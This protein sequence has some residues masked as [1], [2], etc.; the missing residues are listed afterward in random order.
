[1]QLNYVDWLVIALY[2]LFNLAVALYLRKRAT[3][4]VSDFFVSGRNVSWWLAGTSMVA[5]TFAADTPLVVTG[6]VARNGIA[7]NWIWWSMVFSGMLT[8]F[9]YAKLWRRAGVL[10]D[11]EFAEIRYHGKPAAFL[12][13]FRAIY[14]GLP[15]NLI[16]M[17]WVN[18]AIVKIMMSVLGISKIEALFFAILIMFITASISSLSGLWGVLWTDM[19]QFFLKMSMVILLAVYAVSATGGMG[20]LV[21]K[22]HEIDQSRDPSSS[23]LSFVP[24]LNSTWMPMITFFVFIA[25]NWWASWYPGAEPGGGGYVAQRIFCAKNEKHSL[26]ATLWFNI[27]HY[28]LRPW[29]WVIVALVAV[30]RYNNDPAFHADPE[31]GYIRILISDLPSY[32]RGLMLAAFA[33]A[34]MSTIGTQLNWGASY[35]VNDVYRRFIPEKSEKHYVKFSQVVTMVLMILSAIV[36]FY[37]DSIASAWQFLMA[38]G[39][40]TG[41]VYILRWFWWRINAWSEISAMASAFVVSLVLQFGFGLTESNPKDFAYLLLITTGITTAVWLTVTFLTKPEPNEVLLSFYRR[42]RPNATM[43]A[44]IAK[45]ATDIVPQKDGLFNLMNWVSGVIMIYCTLFGVGR[46]VLGDT[47]LGIVLLAIGIFFGG[48]IYYNMNR[49]GWETL[50]A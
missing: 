19:F 50:S 25:V 1:M 21:T 46:I 3:Q 42:V 40:G 15:I 26:L 44:P 13:I 38:I 48:L 10:T 34:Y 23:I 28:A 6:L 29:P 24:D 2:F 41:L 5:T 27:A 49:K 16:I 36:T 32:F 47:L 39:A 33:A 11:V 18:L 35:L 7:G 14:L 20:T 9:F 43:W 22:L 45:Q 30:V 37:M 8:V 4:S 12:R 17:G 31:S